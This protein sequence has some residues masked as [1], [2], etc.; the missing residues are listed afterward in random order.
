MS[1]NHDTE[2]VKGMRMPSKLKTMKMNVHEINYLISRKL[3]KKPG[4]SKDSCNFSDRKTST[5]DIAAKEYSRNKELIKKLR[6][7]K[8]NDSTDSDEKHSEERK[9]GV[10]SNDMIINRFYSN[11]GGSRNLAYSNH[12]LI[13]CLKT[14]LSTEEENGINVSKSICSLGERNCLP[15]DLEPIRNPTQQLSF[16]FGG[17]SLQN[18]QTRANKTRRRHRN[19]R[20]REEEVDEDDDKVR[21][22]DNL[23]NQ[24]LDG[25]TSPGYKDI[26]LFLSTQIGISNHPSRQKSQN[27]VISQSLTTKKNRYKPD[28]KEKKLPK[29]PRAHTQI[30]TSVHTRKHTGATGTPK[31]HTMTRIPSVKN[32]E[33]D[34]KS[35]PEIGTQMFPSLP[36]RLVGDCSKGCHKYHITKPITNI[37]ARTYLKIL[38][39][40]E[41]KRKKKLELIREKIKQEE[42]KQKDTAIEVVLNLRKLNGDLKTGRNDTLIPPNL[43]LKLKTK[44]HPLYSNILGSKQPRRDK[45]KRD[46]NASGSIKEIRKRV[47]SLIKGKKPGFGRRMKSMVGTYANRNMI[48]ESRKA[49]Q[50][51]LE[52]IANSFGSK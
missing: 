24:T 41:L 34:L 11:N 37:K 3:S 38:K 17:E 40:K 48:K 13:S 5:Q 44:N 19:I 14:Q 47:S 31:K 39:E 22:S 9:E 42:K 8:L 25:K 29:R 32:S 45:S 16:E 6:T 20:I 27:V 49:H 12:Q 36:K 10:D 4:K 26:R 35:D 43:K 52:S 7:F 28:V 18:K 15:S 50:M 23:E 2:F 46:P 30:Q 33:S 51:V 21:I 1:Y